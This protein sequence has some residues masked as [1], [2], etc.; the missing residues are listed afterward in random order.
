MTKVPD[1]VEMKEEVETKDEDMEEE[2]SS[3]SED[4]EEEEQEDS[5]DETPKAF[6]P[7]KV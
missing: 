2:S 5:K 4:D 7:G 6:L 3:S 1:E